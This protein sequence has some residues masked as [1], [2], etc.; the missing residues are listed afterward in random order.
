VIFAAQTHYDKSLIVGGRIRRLEEF[1]DEVASFVS[2]FDEVL[3]KQH[4]LAILRAEEHAIFCK[5]GAKLLDGDLYAIMSS[6][7]FDS[8]ITLSSGAALEAQFFGIQSYSLLNRSSAIPEA[9]YWPL[10]TQ[11]LWAT[12]FNLG[13]RD[14][15]V[16]HVP[17]HPQR[18]MAIGA[19][20]RS[21]RPTFKVST[22]SPGV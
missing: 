20:L 22:M 18:R 14:S 2:M 10:F 6:G 9:Y 4:P 12:F 17:R 21:K 16:P 13:S 8:L 3:V 5:L 19:S 15:E 1:G 7:R 11:R